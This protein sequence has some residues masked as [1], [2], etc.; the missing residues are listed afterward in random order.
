MNWGWLC[1][2]WQESR[3][4]MSHSSKRH[5][6]ISV[7]VNG[8]SKVVQFTATMAICGGFGVRMFPQQ[9]EGA[10]RVVFSWWLLVS[11]CPAVAVDN[12]ML[13]AAREMGS[14]QLQQMDREHLWIMQFWELQFTV[15]TRH[16]SLVLWPSLGWPNHPVTWWYLV[17]WINFSPGVKLNLRQGLY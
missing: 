9:E 4:T 14:Q 16:T 13:K 6:S 2:S 1:R 12:N 7:S 8:T 11:P 3:A 17:T 10:R 15:G 5:H